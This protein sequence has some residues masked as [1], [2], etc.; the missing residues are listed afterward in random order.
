VNTLDQVYVA[1]IESPFR[2]PLRERDKLAIDRSGSLLGPKLKP[3]TRRFRLS[4]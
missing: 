2:F 1:I 4:L 3:R